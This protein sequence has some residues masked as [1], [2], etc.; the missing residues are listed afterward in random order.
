MLSARRSAQRLLRAR[1]WRPK[2]ALDKKGAR[3][4]AQLPLADLPS[5]LA[6]I[7]TDDDMAD[8]PLAGI[9]SKSVFYPAS[10]FDGRPVQFLAGHFHS[11]IYADYGKTKTELAAA[12]EG[13]GFAGYRLLAKR[14]VS[15]E[16]LCP[17]YSEAQCWQDHPEL[18]VQEDWFRAFIK[19]HFCQWLIFERDP[20]LGQQHG[21]SRFSLLYMCCD[22]LTTYQA[23]YVSNHTCPAAI[24]IIQPGH[25]FGGNWTNF[26][27]PEGPLALKAR[28]NPAGQP[29][30]LLFGG[31]GSKQ[32]Y[33]KPCWPDYRETLGF[34]GHSP[35]SL[36]R[37]A[38]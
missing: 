20:T 35:V 5:W 16:E 38:R 37:L 15:Q 29:E 26:E 24:A 36:W 32:F 22:G 6:S 3:M 23:L 10:G 28:G 21:P 34:L 27:D 25:G 9:L 30:F 18:A 13:N 14:D 33:D 8:I 17:N 12:L 2:S 7:E 11:F 19:P 31:E 1:W 4:I